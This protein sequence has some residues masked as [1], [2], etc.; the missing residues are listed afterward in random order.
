M[1]GRVD[2]LSRSWLL[3]NATVLAY[4]S[5]DEGFGFPLLD[6]MQVGLPIAA[7]NRGS[8]PE[9][10]GNAGLLCEPDDVIALA[11]NLATAAFDDLVRA[12]L[13]AAAAAQLATFSWHRC[14]ADLTALYRRL[15]DEHTS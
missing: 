4:P 8:I 7:S 12:Q 1:T 10:C 3:R 2:E 14:A 6:A 15:A 5:L 9:V 13:L 11:T